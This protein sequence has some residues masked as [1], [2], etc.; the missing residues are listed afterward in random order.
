M[1]TRTCDGIG[2]LTYK[3]CDMDGIEEPKAAVRAGN[4]VYEDAGDRV[5]VRD[6]GGELSMEASKGTLKGMYME[7][8]MEDGAPDG[9]AIGYA[10]FAHFLMGLVPDAEFVAA[11]AREAEALVM[12]NPALYGGAEL[13]EEGQAAALEDVRGLVREAEAAAGGG[14]A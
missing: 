13:D 1:R 11:V 14:D 12:R 5:R 10:A 9:A 8:L 3:I 4:F 6:I 2:K 7:M